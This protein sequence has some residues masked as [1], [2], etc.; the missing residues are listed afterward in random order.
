MLLREFR[1]ATTGFPKEFG[2]GMVTLHG[3]FTFKAIGEKKLLKPTTRDLRA[4]VKLIEKAPTRGWCSPLEGLR[5]GAG[6][7]GKQNETLDTIVLWA[8]G[9]P[10]GG[11]YMTA[12]SAALAWAHH[13]RFR[14]LRVHCIRISNRKEQAE[15]FMK[16]VAKSS[17][18][19]YVWANKPPA[20]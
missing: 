19:T 11:R 7:G 18:G 14:R 10:S 5:T 2:W 4:G 12:D 20:K 3:P 8:T 9:D 1:K 6:L 16:K 13:N 17:G 15:I